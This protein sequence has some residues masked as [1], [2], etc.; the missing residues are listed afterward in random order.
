MG[1]LYIDNELIF[2]VNYLN[3]KRNGEGK[4]Y[5]PNKHLLF[6]GKYL[7]DKKWEGKGY[8]NSGQFEY[9]INNGCGYIKEFFEYKSIKFEGEYANGEKNG[10]GKEYN[11]EGDLIF[12][13]EF[14]NGERNGKGKDYNFKNR[15]IEFEGEYKNGKRW[16]VIGYNDKG[17]ISCEIKEGNGMIKKFF[18][19]GKINFEGEYKMEKEMVKEN[20]IKKILSQNIIHYCMKVNF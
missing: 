13:G 19:D 14:K 4:E 15:N 2:E 7:D 10:I 8:N 9:E 17:E 16:N 5:Y 20:N 3:N 18:E 12:E 11:K 1:K 6:Q